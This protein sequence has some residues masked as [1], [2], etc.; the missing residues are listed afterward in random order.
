MI[1]ELYNALSYKDKDIINKFKFNDNKLYI[2]YY[3]CEAKWS[4]YMVK[5]D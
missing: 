4:D 2:D 3:C 1:N 5:K